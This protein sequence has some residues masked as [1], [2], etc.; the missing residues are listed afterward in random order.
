MNLCCYH[1]WRSVPLPPQTHQH[2]LLLVFLILSHSVQGNESI[3]LHALVQHYL[4]KMLSFSPACIFGLF[5]KNQVYIG[6]QIYVLV[7][8]LIPLINRFVFMPIP[9]IFYYF[10][11]AV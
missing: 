3:L 7:L 6:V 11:S 4:L 1:L 5:M 8:K 2:E 10:S 9:L